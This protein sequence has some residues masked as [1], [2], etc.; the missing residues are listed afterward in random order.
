ML[1]A[2]ALST[3]LAS[4]LPE[5]PAAKI[6]AATIVKMRFMGLFNYNFLCSN[7]ISVDEAQHIMCFFI[8]IDDESYEGQKYSIFPHT[9]LFICIFASLKYAVMFLFKSFRSIDPE[10]KKRRFVETYFGQVLLVFIGASFSILLTLGA[11]N[12]IQKR[13]RRENQRLS[14]MMVMSNIESFARNLDD[15]AKHMASNDSIATWLIS[16]P[17][18]D[19]ELMPER[20]LNSLIDQ[21]TDFLF[22]S[23]DKSAENIFTNNI[24]TWKNIGNLQFIDRVGQC[25]AAMNSVEEYW[26]NRVNDVNETVLDIKDH[27]DN[28][29]GSSVPIKILRSS[30][31]R[32]T[33]TGIHYL[34]AYLSYVAATMRYQNLNNM[35]AIGITEKEIMDFTNAREHESENPNEDPDFNEYYSDPINPDS[36]ITLDNLNLY[37]DS[38][39]RL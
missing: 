37:L 29:E 26:N 18:E 39:K 22:I 30:K 31:M 2:V 10:R 35:A 24:E 23:R 7:V 32:R 15:H 27:P 12:F 28:Y 5:R 19:L 6:R 14:A 17:I 25:F 8:L 13:E 20:E 11:A 3:G 16:R 9:C 4:I 33:L 38:L 21:A 1:A 36:L 34:K